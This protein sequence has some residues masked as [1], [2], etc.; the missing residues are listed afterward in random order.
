MDFDKILS[1]IKHGEQRT[2][3]YKKTI[4][5]IEKLGKSLCGMLNVKGGYGFIGISDSKKIIG[6]EVT[7]STRKKLTEFCNSFDPYPQIEIHYV[8]IPDS[9]KFIIV[10]SCKASKEDA[11]YTFRSRPYLKTESGVRPM[12]PEKYQH[13]LLEHVGLSKAWESMSANGFTVDDLDSTEMLRTMKAGLAKGSIPQEEYTENVHEILTQFDLIQDHKLNNAAMVLFAKKMPADYSQCFIR[14]G[15]FVDDTMDVTLDSKQ[16]RGNAFQILSAAEDFV[17]RHIPIS[18][19]FDP[20]QFERVEKTALPLVAVREAIINAIIHRDYSK[21]SGDIALM[22][23]N[24]ALEIH[25]VGHLYG[26][27]TI[28][29]LSVRHPSRRRNERISQVFYGRGLI[30]RWGG[31]TRRILKLCLD[32]NLPEPAFSEETDGFLVRFTFKEPIGATLHEPSTLPHGLKEREVE[33]LKILG[34]S[35]QPLSI[36]EIA[37]RLQNPPADRTLQDNFMHL[38]TLGLVTLEG[39][40]RSAKWRLADKK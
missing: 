27:L 8:E 35:A 31:G 13:L 39:I 22:I 28:D 40:K 26:G 10:F 20:N 1:L 23:F 17:R 4:A 9:D 14:M 33:I 29:Q 15:R 3:E 12:P 36:R 37:Q 5:E 11:P 18:A 2:I 7:D 19:H 38:K 32:E 30:E 16:M 34:E 6:T 25:N 21:P 24:D